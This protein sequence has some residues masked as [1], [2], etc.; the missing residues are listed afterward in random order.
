M[1][2]IALVLAPHFSK[3]SIGEYEARILKA[4][5]ALGAN[6]ELTMVKSWNDEPA[7]VDLVAANP[8]AFRAPLAMSLHNHALILGKAGRAVA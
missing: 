3:K 1:L 4:R 7:F 5:D 8:T 6:F 2:V